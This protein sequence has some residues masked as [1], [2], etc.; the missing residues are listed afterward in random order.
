MVGPDVRIRRFTPKA[1]Q[2][3][4]LI[5]GDIG[6]PI[7]DIEPGIEGVNGRVDLY[8]LVSS[9]MS[10]MVLNEIEAHDKQ[11]AWY[12]VQVRPYR[13]ADNKID[14][15]V[16]SIIDITV[17]KHA[18]DLMKSARDD[19][20]NI[21][22]TTPSPV[23][24][25]TADRRVQVAN[26]SFYETFRSEQSETEGKF[27]S[28]LGDGQWNIP[29]LL[30]LLEAVLN[31]G[32]T[33]KDFE[34]ELDLPRVGHKSLVI[35]ARRTYLAGSATQAALFAIEDATARKEIASELRSSEERYRNLLENAHDGILVVNGKGLIE[36]ANHQANVMFGYSASE[37]IDKP[38]EILIPE[39]SREVHRSHLAAYM[40]EP[41]ARDM[42]TPEGLELY[43][44]R[45]D[46]YEFP[47]DISFS[48]VKKD[49]KVSVTAII[50]DISQRKIVEK[51]RLDI[52]A[53]EKE[54][55]FEAEKANRTKDEFLATLSHELR[56]PLTT[57]K[58]WAQILSLGT[59]DP[60]RSMKG[61]AVIERSANAQSQLIDDL[62]DVS[63]IQSGKLHLDLSV[64]DPVECV[65]AAVDS[66]RSSAAEKSISIE[67]EFDPS[68]G[69]IKADPVR[70]Q[71]VFW[72]LLT[73][74]IKFTPE[75]GKISVRLQLVG[76]PSHQSVQ[77]QVKDTGRGISSD[78]LP[79]LFTRFT[80]ADSSATRGYAGL[81]LGL[82]IVRHLV[83][84]HGGT[85]TAESPGEDKGAVF[86][87]NLPLEQ[88]KLPSGVVRP[89]S[90]QMVNEKA[91]TSARLD[92][93]KVLIID[94]LK[95][96]L[97]G[98]GTF[99][100]SL[101]A[102]VKT[103]ESAAEGFGTLTEFKP[104]VLMC[105][106]AMPGEDGYSLIQRVRALKPG[107]GGKT[108]AIAVTAYA[109]AEDRRRALDAKYD[110]HLAKPVDMVVLSCLIAKLAGKK[111]IE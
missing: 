89:I 4:R 75:G 90:P 64:V 105:D 6:R 83:E 45:K 36:F 67:T 8:D 99:L 91:G 1:G 63:R 20:R 106:I 86:T 70:I 46:G 31:Q 3:L 94:D 33:F 85:V 79:R 28:E 49:S 103:A 21:I 61:L 69:E 92:G 15:A 107:Q 11:G 38:Y 13:T 53:S 32:T 34:I 41:R 30:G 65:S 2:I 52:L 96:A 19:A 71:Q 43:G 24:V 59:P 57:I 35:S 77:I 48:P 78:F 5:A 50:R 68:P 55:R 74:A 98:F 84:M 37:L 51:E 40:Q 88:T 10:S 76:E 12:R 87:V 93:L 29:S 81:G 42:G 17:S 39:H 110:A 109:Q 58:S 104:D 82:S 56:T 27:I 102:H 80:Q 14:G 111:T 95:D 7:S 54:A 22:E 72:N 9:T 66:A 44:R 26:E 97:D 23:L 101:G 60:E 18:A 73:N 100:R 47:V 16:I 62:L 25:I 108:P